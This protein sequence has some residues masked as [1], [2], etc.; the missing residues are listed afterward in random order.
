MS[1][2]DPYT[3]L[4]KLPITAADY[5][6]GRDSGDG[7]ST[8][9]GAPARENS[10]GTRTAPGLPTYLARQPF[11]SCAIQQALPVIHTEELNQ[12]S[13]IVAAAFFAFVSQNRPLDGANVDD[14]P[15]T[16][17][18]HRLTQKWPRI[19][20][21]SSPPPP[22]SPTGRPYQRPRLSQGGASQART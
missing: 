21:G 10:R 11:L 3:A 14:R 12:P 18:C 22:S 16:G 20:F 2:R 6:P 4:L 1:R 15:I 8:A 5:P 7:S 9:S 19:R 13:H 17:K